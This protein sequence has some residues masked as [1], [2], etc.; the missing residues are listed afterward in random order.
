M[1]VYFEDCL[2]MVMSLIL[3]GF[4]KY[5]SLLYVKVATASVFDKTGTDRNRTTYNQPDSQYFFIYLG[6]ILFC[7]CFKSIQYFY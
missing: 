7:I 1:C 5:L 3:L 6:R 4:E 2:A